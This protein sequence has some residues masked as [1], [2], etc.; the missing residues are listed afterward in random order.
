LDN[1]DAVVVRLER[2]TL[3]QIRLQRGD[4]DAQLAS[5]ALTLRDPDAGTAGDVALVGQC[6]D[7]VT[8]KQDRA[9]FV[10]LLL[11]ADV[12]RAEGLSEIADFV[13]DSSFEG[14]ERK[15]KCRCI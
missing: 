6:G 15:L 1:A 12:L 9:K 2:A 11:A 7:A 8:R 10:L 3:Y 13:L 4:R 14:A 5:G